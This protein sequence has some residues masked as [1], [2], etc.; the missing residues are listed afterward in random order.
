MI[1]ELTFTQ[2]VLLLFSIGIILWIIGLVMGITIGK[3]LNNKYMNIEE[4]S[5]EL[6]KQ[7][8]EGTAYPYWII[9]DP[10]QNMDCNIHATASMIS[11]IFFSRKEAQEYLDAKHYNFTDRAKVYCHSGHFSG[12]WRELF[13]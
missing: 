1:V 6:K 12:K 7:D 10:R 8:P 4:I 13:S 9:I 3:R 2:L 11:G 5:K